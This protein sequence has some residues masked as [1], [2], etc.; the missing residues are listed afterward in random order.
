[1]VKMISTEDL[2]TWRRKAGFIAIL[3]GIGFT[4]ITLIAMLFYP[5]GYRFFVHYFRSLGMFYVNSVPNIVSRSL[6][7]IACVWAGLTLIFFWIIMPTLFTKDKKLKIISITGSVLG[8]ISS[9]FLMLLAIYGYD[10]FFFEHFF[11]T[12]L[13]F[14]CSALATLIYSIGII[15]NKEY[16]RQKMVRV[17]SGIFSI[18][19]ILYVLS[20]FGL[21]WYGIF[22]SL[23]QKLIVYGLILWTSFQ[24][25][26]I[27]EEIGK[28]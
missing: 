12:M 2:K 21:R 11:T 6:F 10:L 3:A 16:P 8:L 27:W 14:L 4:V 17:V 22:G 1:M 28:E 13:F 20:F 19:L 23:V 15:I 26:V 5:G 24:V 9:P 25:I 7:I 18:F